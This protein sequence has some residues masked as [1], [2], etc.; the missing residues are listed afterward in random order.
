MEEGPL[1]WEKPLQ[2]DWAT[3]RVCGH[4]SYTR[5]S[6][7]PESVPCVQVF[8]ER[9]EGCRSWSQ[10]RFDAKCKHSAAWGR[11][12]K[13]THPLDQLLQWYSLQCDGSWEHQYGFEITTLDNPAVRLQVDVAGTALQSKPFQRIQH[14]S[15]AGDEWLVCDVLSNGTFD[16]CCSPPLFRQLIEIFVA[17]ALQMDTEFRER[18]IED[19]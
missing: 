3:E 6:R 11:T 13:L 16:G 18:F 10:H 4:T 5:V 9:V 2:Q 1:Y 19:S 14:E 15:S 8:L 12:C 7:A 17:W